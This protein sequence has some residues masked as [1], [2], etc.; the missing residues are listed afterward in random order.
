MSD[1]KNQT[2]PV[3]RNERGQIVAGSGSNGGGR[4]K[5]SLDFMSI[6]RKRAKDEN[7]DLEGL[8]WAV[9]KGLFLRAAKGDAACAKIALD[10]VCGL[11]EKG[12]L[13]NI[14]IDQKQLNIGAGP[15]VPS[16][17]ELGAYFKQLQ[18]IS[19]E[20]LEVELAPDEDEFGGL[21]G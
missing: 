1:S 4:P 21:F 17:R 5:G 6:C 2:K 13:V 3:E 20:L 16:T 18:T 14:D 12:A 15:P 11:L 8:V 9:A 19:G 7:L 10:R